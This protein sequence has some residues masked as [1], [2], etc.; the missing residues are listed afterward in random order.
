MGKIATGPEGKHCIDCAKAD[1]HQD[2]GDNNNIICGDRH[3]IYHSRPPDTPAC[4]YFEQ[5]KS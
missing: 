3:L 4:M 2:T 1:N 5:K